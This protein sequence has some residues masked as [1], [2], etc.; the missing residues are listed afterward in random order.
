MENNKSKHRI[1][2]KSRRR[3]TIFD[4]IEDQKKRYDHMIEAKNQVDYFGANQPDDIFGIK[5]LL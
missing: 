2:I 4:I 5:D 1:E 3:T